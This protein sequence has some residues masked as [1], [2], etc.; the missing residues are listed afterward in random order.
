ME[1]AIFTLKIFSADREKVSA[2]FAGL[3]ANKL[4]PTL[5][6]CIVNLY[7]YSLCVKLFWMEFKGNKMSAIS[8]SLVLLFL[9]FTAIVILSLHGQFVEPVPA[10]IK[11]DYDDDAV[12]TRYFDV[13]GNVQGVFFRKV[14][15]TT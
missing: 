8:P 9:V 13:Y 4:L 15:S 5:I 3:L 1:I 11:V 10:F 14:S 6:R 12:V 7:F 2:T